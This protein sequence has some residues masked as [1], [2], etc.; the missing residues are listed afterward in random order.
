M[1]VRSGASAFGTSAASSWCTGEN[2]MKEANVLT[3]NYR[4]TQGLL[5]SDDSY[6]NNGA[7]NIPYGNEDGRLFAVVSD[8]GGWDHVS[9]SLEHRCPTW[10]EMCYAKDL[11]FREEETVIQYHPPKSEYVN[12]HE[13]CLHL[14]RP[15]EDW[16]KLPPAVFVSV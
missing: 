13:Y 9:I 5:A 4:I 12:D 14:W 16:I 7:F 15:H 10:E 3:E 1:S 2:D 11:F 6:G 8:G